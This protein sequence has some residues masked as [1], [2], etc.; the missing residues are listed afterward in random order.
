[1][2][3]DRI[4]IYMIIPKRA[5]EKLKRVALEKRTTMTELVLKFIE[6]L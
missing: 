1:M 4:G 5:K 6:K 2:N 3:K